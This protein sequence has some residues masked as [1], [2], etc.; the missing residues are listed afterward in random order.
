M[1]ASILVVS[2]TASASVSGSDRFDSF[3]TLGMPSNMPGVFIYWKLDM[4]NKRRKGL[5]VATVKPF[6]VYAVRYGSFRWLRSGLKRY[7][8]V[9]S[10]W[11]KHR[12]WRDRRS[13]LYY[14]LYWDKAAKWQ[15][16]I[17]RFSNQ[18]YTYSGRSQKANA[19]FDSRVPWCEVEAMIRRAFKAWRQ[20]HPN[21]QVFC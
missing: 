16:E 19:R 12:N 13:F 2:S 6:F 1:T 20:R 18:F 4:S 10:L 8:T 17:G 7:R 14:C 5:A 15:T 11:T 3:P 21:Y 9:R